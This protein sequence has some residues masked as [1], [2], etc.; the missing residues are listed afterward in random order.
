MFE[1]DL[2]LTALDLPQPRR[3]I[4][5][6]GREGFAVRAELDIVYPGVQ[7]TGFGS[8]GGVCSL[9][10]LFGRFRVPNEGK[11]SVRGRESLAIVA[12]R[13]PEPACTCVPP[14][15]DCPSLHVQN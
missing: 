1:P 14:V 6:T 5:A 10:N 4:P 7:S 3:A 8:G 12:E 11:V 2:L 15:S 13:E 9:K